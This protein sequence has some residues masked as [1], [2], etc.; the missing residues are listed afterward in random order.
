MP[1]R[2]IA[3]HA[4]KTIFPVGDVGL[5]RDLSNVAKGEMGRSRNRLNTI[6]QGFSPGLRSAKTALKEAAERV[7]LGHGALILEVA[8][9][10]GVFNQLNTPTPD[11]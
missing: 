8:R 2:R 11:A 4:S 5:C 3:W 7:Y 10:L 1:G 6:A 9:T